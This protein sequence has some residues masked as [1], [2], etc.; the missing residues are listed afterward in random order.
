MCAEKPAQHFHSFARRVS[1]FI[2]A[3]KIYKS[4]EIPYRTAKV[5]PDSA[6]A[7]GIALAFPAGATRPGET[8]SPTI[9]G[10]T[11]Q[12]SSVVQRTT[13]GKF[14]SHG[15]STPA[16]SAARSM[17]SSIPPSRS[18]TKLKGLGTQVELAGGQFPDVILFQIPPFRHPR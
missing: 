14:V 10:Y 13:A 1:V 17:A 9:P 12:S 4:I 8:S 16:I 11:R 7:A 3:R 6:V 15:F 5:S 18:E 2:H